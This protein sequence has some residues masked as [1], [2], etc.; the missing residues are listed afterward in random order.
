MYG[1]DVRLSDNGIGDN[2][3]TVCSEWYLRFTQGSHQTYISPEFTGLKV[4]AK[5]GFNKYFC[6]GKFAKG[7]N[8]K[9]TNFLVNI[10]I[11]Q[12][13]TSFKHFYQPS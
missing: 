2:G 12:F 6:V 8:S 5:I 1:D 3:T 13:K 9:Y 4:K 11:I 7:K 10:F